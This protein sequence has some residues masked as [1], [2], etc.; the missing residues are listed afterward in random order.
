MIQRLQTLY[1][2]AASLLL[3]SW[4]FS[5][6][7]TFLVG[8]QEFSFGVMGFSTQTVGVENIYLR[9]WP[10]LVLTAITCFISVVTIFL[11]KRRMVQIRLSMFNL[12]ALLGLVGLMVYYVYQVKSV[13]DAAAQL[14]VQATSVIVQYSLVDAFP[15]VAAL[16]TYLALRRIAS[17][18]ALVRSMDRLR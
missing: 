18:E 17:D 12:F 14:S 4:F 10:L 9:T 7:A 3:L 15:L 5:P 13:F 2:A 8:G 1:L 6:L 11:Y 16:L